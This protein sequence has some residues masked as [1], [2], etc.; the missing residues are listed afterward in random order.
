MRAKP[1]IGRLLVVVLILSL[2]LGACGGGTTGST[3]F[4]LPSVRLSMNDNGTAKIYGIPLN[5]VILQPSVIQML[6]SASVQRVEARIG[7]N[8]I[9]VYL[10]GEDMPYVAWDATSTENLQSVLTAL[11][12]TVLPY[13]TQIAKYLPWLR[14][15][16]LGVRL[17]IP[18]AN[19]TI[20]NWSGETAVTPETPEATTIGPLVI[21]SLVFDENGEAIIEGIPLSQLEQDMGTTLPLRLDAGVL[22]ILDAI[23]ADSVKI[24]T[25][26]NGIDIFLNEEQLPGIAYDSAY[27]ERTIPYIDA[28]VTD[29][30]MAA[31][32]N[33]LIPQLPGADV[34][35][36]VSFTGEP[37]VA[38]DLGSITVVAA[39]DGSL[40]LESGVP[41]AS[42]SLPADLLANLQKA[43][44][45]QLGV[46]MT[47]DTLALT[48]NGQVLPTISFSEDSLGTLADLVGPIAGVAPSLI[49]EGVGVLRNLGPDV[50]LDLPVAEGAEAVDIPEQPD[51]TM[52]AADIGDVNAPTIHLSAKYGADGF[53][54]LG[55]ISAST[56][57]LLGITLPTLPPDVVSLLNDQGVGE[58]QLVVADGAL[59]VNTD[60]QTALTVNYDTDSLQAALDIASPFLGEDSPL[61]QPVMSRFIQEQLL[62]ILPAADVVITL[63]L[64]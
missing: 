62:P 39:E 1:R 40:K 26:P 17:D 44:V 6:Q 9:H 63:T 41:L 11:P 19:M 21:G 23:G 52:K 32:L 49:T 53:T 58:V 29:P 5:Q 59:V 36:V 24:A 57:D 16:G 15:I 31:L 42:A 46:N 50:K 18:P 60:G 37:A 43:N 51:L 27:L 13:G 33:Q 61:N 55:G 2:V 20:A 8:G 38:T 45:Q 4:N 56:L 25:Q 28:F 34:Q 48:A 10:N 12:P 7:Y 22:A 47:A 35:V 30:A 54:E 64:E 14:K 3:W